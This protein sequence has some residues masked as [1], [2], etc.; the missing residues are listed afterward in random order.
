MRPGSAL[1]GIARLV[2][3]LNDRRPSRLP[4]DTVFVGTR[5]G[6]TML[7]NQFGEDHWHAGCPF[8][9]GRPL[10]LNMAVMD[11][12]AL[13]HHPGIPRG[14]A[15][16]VSSAQSPVFLHGPT[17]ASCAG[18]ALAVIRRYGIV[19]PPRGTPGYPWGVRIGVRGDRGADWAHGK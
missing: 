14:S 7:E 17:R 6:M 16:A 12:L 15:F 11:G 8:Y 9:G 1:Y 5:M 2:L 18:G 10:Y 4:L 13:L 19:E 3:R